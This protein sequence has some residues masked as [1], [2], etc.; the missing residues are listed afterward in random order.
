M[1]DEKRCLRR[2]THTLFTSVRVQ[3]LVERKLEQ[4]GDTEQPA[5]GIAHKHLQANASSASRREET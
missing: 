1:I 5:A 2:A 4:W 3:R